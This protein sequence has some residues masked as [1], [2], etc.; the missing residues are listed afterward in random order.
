M[1]SAKSLKLNYFWVTQTGQIYRE[2][3]TV[4]LD[5][6]KRFMQMYLD[7]SENCIHLLESM[8]E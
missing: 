8:E 2:L 5:F 4:T 1:K 3:E 6:G 7:W